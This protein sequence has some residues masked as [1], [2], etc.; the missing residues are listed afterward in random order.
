M[1]KCPFFLLGISASAIV[2]WCQSIQKLLDWIQTLSVC[3]LLGLNR[4][5][6]FSP[7]QQVYSCTEETA[8]SC[9]GCTVY[10][11]VY[12]EPTP[13]PSVTGSCGGNTGQWGVVS[14]QCGWPSVN[15]HHWW[16]CDERVSQNIDHTVRNVMRPDPGHLSRTSLVTWWGRWA[17]PGPPT[18]TPTPTSSTRTT[19]PGS[20]RPS[21]RL[22][23][24]TTRPSG[25][26]RGSILSVS[27]TLSVTMS[28]FS[29]PSRFLTWT[30]SLSGRTSP[31]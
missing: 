30:A 17:C 2:Y 20:T 29:S 25:R 5:T 16:H 1:S 23:T 9:A 24:G 18:L 13:G 21:R 15:I 12:R 26:L 10:S 19:P 3:S 31:L 6:S 28:C 22:P 27:R 8:E 14:G 7:V 11:A 4:K